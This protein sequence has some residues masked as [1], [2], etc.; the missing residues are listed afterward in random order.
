MSA[1]ANT[2]PSATSDASP[3]H[4]ELIPG[5]G[6]SFGN[7][8]SPHQTPA[9]RHE[10]RFSTNM[11]YKFDVFL[12]YSR[13]F[14]I[15]EWVRKFFV[16]QLEFWLSQEFPARKARIFW[17]QTGIEPGDY[18]SD[19]LKD[20]LRESACLVP[21]WAPSYFK[22]KWC[23]AE[24]Y[25]FLKR[26]S[27]AKVDSRRLIIPLRWH[28][29]DSFPP[30]AQ[31][32]LYCPFEKH[33]YLIRETKA[34]GDFQSAVQKFATTIKHAIDKA[35]PFQPNWPVTE[36]SDIDALVST[37]PDEA[38]RFYNFEPQFIPNPRSLIPHEHD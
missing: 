20:G 8:P 1:W 29:G 9:S 6:A 4:R 18:W 21:V 33:T 27:A 19:V 23:V 10:F 11:P 17:D 2:I 5:Q 31:Q 16:A 34:F 22:S 32:I 36:P 7:Q 14:L 24:F 38:R 3:R 30:A 15:E 28:D 26:A 35:P 13:E 12:S 37:Y 25:S